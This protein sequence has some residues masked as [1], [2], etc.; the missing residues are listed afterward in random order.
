MNWVLLL[1]MVAGGQGMVMAQS[2]GAERDLKHKREIVFV[3]EHGAALSVMAAAYFNKLTRE[4]HLNLHAIARGITPQ[5]D[6]SVKAR[7]GLAADGIAIETSHPLALSSQDAA[8]A[9][10]II[11]F[12][13]IPATF[14]KM[15]P[16]E[17]WDDVTWPPPNYGAARDAI[18]KHLHEL[19]HEL[20]EERK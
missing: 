13:S 19:I 5:P 1:A 17:N 4:Q 2:A 15:A 20:K 18:L 11:A 7:Q 8:H 16:V 3:C 6:L 14:A 10:R 9:R 12:F